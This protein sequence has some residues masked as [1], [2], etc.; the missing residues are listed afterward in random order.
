VHDQSRGK[1]PNIIQR[2]QTSRAAHAFSIWIH[3]A[4]NRENITFESARARSL[5][6]C[7]DLLATSS[8]R[9]VGGANIA[10]AKS[11]RL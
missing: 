4:E 6:D 9:H 10:N 1:R 7:D 3:P 8:A 5:A 11:S 2:N